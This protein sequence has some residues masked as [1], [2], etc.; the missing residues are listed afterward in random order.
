MYRNKIKFI[1]IPFL[2]IIDQILKN[3]SFDNFEFIKNVVSYQK[4]YNHGAAFNILSGHSNVIIIITILISII[5][6]YELYKNE[7]LTNIY[8]ILLISGILSNF[9]DRLLHKYVI[10]YISILKF[11]VFN[12][13]DVYIVLGV[14]LI[15]YEAFN[16]RKN[17]INSK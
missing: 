6:V 8:S 2:L 9:L 11:P 13:G 17:E 5:L 10:D 4:T 7:K 16:E 15:V 3:V 12:L 14:G 1:L